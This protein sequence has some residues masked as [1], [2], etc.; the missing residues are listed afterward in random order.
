MGPLAF[1][2]DINGAN[3]DVFLFFE[4]G[5]GGDVVSCF[6]LQARIKRRF[7]K[8]PKGGGIT[9]KTVH[10]YKDVRHGQNVVRDRGSGPTD[11]IAYDGRKG[12]TR[13]SFLEKGN[14]CF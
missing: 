10:H 4:V 7:P 1:T 9:C 12:R 6:G 13:I 3:G 8:E 11:H 5:N 14:Q 2:P